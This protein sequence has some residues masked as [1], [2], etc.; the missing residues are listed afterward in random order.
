[1]MIKTT[2]F[3]HCPHVS[4]TQ[5]SFCWWPHNRSLMTSQWWDN[6]DT[7]MWIVISNS[8]EI[9]ILFQL[10][11]MAVCVRNYGN[12]QIGLVITRST[13]TTRTLAFWDTPH[14]PMITHTSDSHQIPSQNKTKSKL[15]IWKK[16]LPKIHILKFCKR[17]YTPHTCSSSLIRCINMK[18][19]QPEL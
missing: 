10:I 1:M 6:C 11:F 17:R 14:R 12:I 16:K 19:I 3:S 5:F 18:W 15:Q 2:I 8:L 13:R 9:S 7:N 4:L